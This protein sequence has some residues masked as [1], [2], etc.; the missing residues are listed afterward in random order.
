MSALNNAVAADA[1][2][3]QAPT[4]QQGAP[5]GETATPTQEGQAAPAEQ[6]PDLFEGTQINPDELPDELKPLAKQ[7]QAAFTQK[8]QMLAEERKQFEALGDPTAVQQAVELY[9]R[10][11]DPNNWGQLYSELTTA[12]QQAGMTLPQAQ[13]AAAEAMTNAAAEQQAPL[14]QGFEDLDPELHPLV[15]QLQETQARLDAFEQRASQ[16]AANREAERQHILLLNE[17]TRQ[18]QVVRESHPNWG[19]DKIEAVYEMSSF[20]GGNLTQAAARLDQLLSAE[21]ELYLS[22]KGA[23]MMESTR[24][25][26]P[27]SAATQT[28]RVSEPQTLKEAEAEATDF[29]RARLADLGQ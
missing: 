3:E 4:T 13:A 27:N 19:D 24:T 14:P 10:I 11:A 16:E 23:A 21:R 17:L 8:T 15:Q 5:A 18:E 26:A 25:P 29:F 22:Q 28:Q 6:N 1:A 20:Y 12:M 2:V 7:L 9:H